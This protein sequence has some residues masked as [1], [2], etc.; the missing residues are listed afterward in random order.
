MIYFINYGP[1]DID[2]Y[3]YVFVGGESVPGIVERVG[4]W[5]SGDAR[6]EGIVSRDSQELYRDLLGVNLVNNLFIKLLIFYFRCVSS[7]GCAEAVEGSNLCVIVGAVY[8]DY[9][10]AGYTSRLRRECM[11]DVSPG[12]VR[13]EGNDFADIDMAAFLTELAKRVT[14]VTELNL[15]NDA[16]PWQRE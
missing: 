15:V 12:R 8:S 14:Y 13:M 10:L 16:N 7:P 2:V 6:R 9:N 3:I 1:N 5:H 11:I 4:L